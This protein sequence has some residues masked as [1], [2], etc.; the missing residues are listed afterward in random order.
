MATTYRSF[1]LLTTAARQLV[2][3]GTAGD[4][5][6]IVIMISPQQ[7]GGS[8]G[9]FVGS[10]QS[11]SSTTGVQIPFGSVPVFRL[12][13][14]LEL[15]GLATVGAQIVGV[16]ITEPADLSAAFLRRVIQP[17]I[18]QSL[19]NQQRIVALLEAQLR[20]AGAV[21]PAAARGFARGRAIVVPED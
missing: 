9:I 17:M 20:A 7:G 8:P 4:R 16:L 15:W 21:V 1:R 5:R 11:V 10:D 12:D 13:A 6:E 3:T 19:A 2:P 18:A 14:E